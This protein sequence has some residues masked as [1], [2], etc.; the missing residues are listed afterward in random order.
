MRN[1]TRDPKM[2]ATETRQQFSKLLSAVA[3]RIYVNLVMTTPVDTGRA[4]SNWIATIGSPSNATRAAGSASAAIRSA[5]QVFAP[6]S[7]PKEGATLYITNNLDY[8]VFLNQGSSK[9]APAHFVE[10]AIDSVV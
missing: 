8:V 5:K 1:W 2:F 3:M 10:A 7:I 9:Q 6:K 4:R